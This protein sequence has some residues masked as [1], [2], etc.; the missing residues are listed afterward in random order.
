MAL[1]DPQQLQVI[2]DI[3]EALSSCERKRLFYLCETPDTDNSASCMKEM[4]VR[5]V[6]SQRDAGH[7]LLRELMVQLGRFDILKQVC[8]TSRGEVE[9]ALQ[10]RQVLPTFRVLMANIS[11]EMDSKDLSSVKFL[12]SSTLTR[13][14]M[15]KMQSFL[16]TIIELEKLD[17]VSPERVDFV[18]ELLKNIDRHDLAKKVTVYKTSVVT[19]ERPSQQQRLITS[20]PFPASNSSHPQQQTRPTQLR[21]NAAENIP[22]SIYRGQSCQS[23]LDLYKFNTNPRGICVIIDCVGNDGGMLEQTFKAL[24]FN[25]ILHKWLSVDDTLSVLR[26][27]RRQ[28][29]N[30]EG[31]AFVCCIISRGMEDNLLG[32][33]S[34]GVGIHLDNIRRLF[35]ADKCPM[36][37][38]KP[39][40]FFIQRY[41]ITRFQPFARMGQWD[42]AL[43]TDGC[44]MPPRNAVI[45]ADADVF[46]SHCWTD[47]CHLEQG[48]H[49]SIYLKALTDALHKGQ[50]RKTPLIDAHTEV[51]G[52]IFEHN[53]RNPGEMYHIELKH[54]L[55]KDLLLQ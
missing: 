18:E 29:E 17:K 28:R 35:T 48:H 4:L 54:T 41:N 38:G 24:H 10:C 26:E 36:L 2:N 25:V 13:E 49:R 16:D 21:H 7:L 43:E 5:K 37:A 32:T 42:E 12:L 50:R 45:P 46:W 27:I 14:K 8:H 47:E 20:H 1:P 44:D 40:L 51:N 23:H 19:P 31:D 3:A 15:E 55:C 52:V 6:T 39:K 9:R 33:D 22:V 11:E 53:R 30:L 34:C